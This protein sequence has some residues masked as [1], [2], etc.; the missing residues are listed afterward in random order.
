VIWS[1]EQAGPAM[2]ATIDLAHAALLRGAVPAK[3]LR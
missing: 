3:L 2:H 1:R